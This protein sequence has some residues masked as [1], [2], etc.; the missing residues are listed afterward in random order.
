MGQ[1]ARNGVLRTSSY[2]E[3]YQLFESGN[4]VEYTLWGEDPGADDRLHGPVRIDSSYAFRVDANGVTRVHFSHS[5]QLD[6]RLLDEDFSTL[7]FGDGSSLVGRDEIYADVR[8]AN[9]WNGAIVYRVQTQTV[10]GYF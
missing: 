3:A 5:I 6:W 10:Y 2:A 9:S 4:R 8:L 7:A 1:S